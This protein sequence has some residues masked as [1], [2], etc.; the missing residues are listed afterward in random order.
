[1]S[2]F[3]VAVFIFLAILAE[4]L[5]TVGGFG[6]SIYFVPLAEYFLDFQSVLGITALFHVSSN[7]TKIGLFRQ[8]IDR[9]IL[10]Y[11]G[12]PA[13]L[14]VILGAVLSRYFKK[15]S[16]ELGISILLVI[17][18]LALLLFRNVKMNINPVNSIAGGALS[19]FV[20]GL[21]GTGGAIRGLVLSAFQLEKEVYIASSAIIDLGVD[22]S[23]SIVYV[24]NGY[25]HR[26]ILYLV[27]LLILVSLMGTYLGKLIL[28][29]IPTERFQKLTLLLILLI[30]I[31]GIVKV[32]LRN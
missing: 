30:G 27:P 25:V 9:R 28:N 8:G 22:L 4:I 10:I 17:L 1:M 21:M 7:L 13:V 26:D 32:V 11:L 31:A 5:G 15:E 6:S 23:R 3:A 18:G 29:R 2:N 14:F 20:A 24:M 12:I 16:F 19:G